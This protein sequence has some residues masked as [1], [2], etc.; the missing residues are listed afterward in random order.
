MSRWIAPY[1]E[2]LPSDMIVTAVEGYRIWYIP[3]EKKTLHSFFIVHHEWKPC[4]RVEAECLNH[5]TCAAHMYS[6]ATAITH[7]E[8]ECNAGVY[9]FKTQAQAWEE[10][11]DHLEDLVQCTALAMEENDAFV[12]PDPRLRIAIGK[13]YLWGKVLECTKGFRGQY[14]YPSALF[15]TASNSK[16]LA[17]MYR[18]PLLALNDYRRIR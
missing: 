17:E 2:T 15:D 1:E 12:A 16:Q 8:T 18:V 9:A 6:E 13:V 7:A 14:A 3:V 5:L 11:I 10:Y 4:Q